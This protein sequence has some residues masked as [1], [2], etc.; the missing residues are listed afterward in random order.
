MPE[1]LCEKSFEYTF[2]GDY[3]TKISDF[4]KKEIGKQN[5]NFVKGNA[6]DKRDVKR[7]MLEE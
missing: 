2:L 4:L 7:R 6:A 1:T 3:H 5:Y